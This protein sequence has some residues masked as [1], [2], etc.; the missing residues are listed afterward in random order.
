MKHQTIRD[1]DGD[2]LQAQAL[3]IDNFEPLGT[4]PGGIEAQ[5][6]GPLGGGRREGYATFRYQ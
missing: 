5:V 6:E 1:G 4:E 3:R 2:A